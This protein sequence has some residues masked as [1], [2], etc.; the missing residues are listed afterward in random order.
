[1]PARFAHEN[2]SEVL[3]KA[4]SLLAKQNVKVTQH[5]ARAYIEWDSR[6][7]EIRRIN[8]PVL[9]R[10][11]DEEMRDVIIGYLDHEVA[12]ALYTKPREQ[13]KVEND[14]VK[15][16]GRPHVL[17]RSLSNIIEDV[18]IEVCME[19]DFKGSARYLDKTRAY[20]LEKSSLKTIQEALDAGDTETA[21]AYA[22]VPFFRAR[23]GQA[24]CEKFMDEHKLWDLCA[25]FDQFFPDLEDRLDDLTSSADAARLAC[26]IIDKFPQ[27]TADDEGDDYQDQDQDGGDDQ[28]DQNSGD[29]GESNKDNQPQDKDDNEDNADEQE[30]QEQDDEDCAGDGDG[31]GEDEDD[32]EDGEG[33]SGQS[34]DG[35]DEDEGADKN[36]GDDDGEADGEDE[37][38]SEGSADG[39]DGEDEGEDSGKG[40]GNTSAEGDEEGN[41][42]N[43]GD[44]GSTDDGGEDSDDASDKDK[45]KEDGGDTVSGGAEEG[46]SGGAPEDLQ[47]ADMSNLPEQGEDEDDSGQDEDEAGASD[48]VMNEEAM[49]D[50]DESMADLIEVDVAMADT[51]DEY[52]VFSY[53]HD[54]LGLADSNAYAPVEKFEKRVAETSSA[55]RKNIERLIAARSLRV[56]VP[57]KRRGR[58]HAPSL[59]RLR[60]D[61]D[62][63]F[64]TRHETPSKNT[65]IALGID[66][67]GSMAGPKMVTA[68]EA[69]WAFSEVLTRINV[70][71]EVI[72]FTTGHTWGIPPGISREEYERFER[73]VAPALVRPETLH[74]PIF[75]TFD[76][77]FG[78]EQ[79]RR[80]AHYPGNGI[81]GANIDG[82]SIRIMARRLHARR[83]ERKILMVF[84]DGR[85]ASMVGA[86]VM[87]DLRR[88][89][90][91]ISS[92][93]IETCG[94]GIKDQTVRHYYDRAFVIHSLEQLGT[95]MLGEL[96]RV[97]VG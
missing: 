67:S 83:E 36:E 65:A 4:A 94:I 59:H 33:S 8:V 53:D 42:E 63:V 31:E 17:V 60:T 15:A 13:R 78:I 84:S 74:M 89:V 61:D 16:S 72:G 66:L 18:R 76:E 23:G 39:E 88:A 25:A 85:P 26:E 3:K 49:E 75:K 14:Y 55:L 91:E 73:L 81:S 97:L 20:F 80:L 56:N 58:I 51:S 64:S 71:N 7:Y 96:K 32:A 11:A 45:D 82:E 43:E 9:P 10:D 68:I 27:P 86:P 30:Q 21:R 69:A 28:D 1:M 12:H 79:K 44:A 6:T 54:F 46:G 57:G 37:N 92:A 2:Y 24:V 93:G 34:E 52:R 38:D 19:R 22:A 70:P 48:L 50:F 62:R 29:E 95:T 77:G 5:G 40:D 87:H 41:D 90:Q 35:E 47:E